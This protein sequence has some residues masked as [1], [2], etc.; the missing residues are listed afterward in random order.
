MRTHRAV[1]VELP[2]PVAEALVGLALR[3]FRDPRAQATKF[4]VEGLRRAGAL[5]H[6]EPADALT[7]ATTE[8]QPRMAVS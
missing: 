5:P 6:E 4:V 7:A 3:E 8:P 1:Y 2:L